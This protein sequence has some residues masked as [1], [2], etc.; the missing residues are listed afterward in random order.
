MKENSIG[1]ASGCL[2]EKLSFQPL[3]GYSPAN[4]R[5]SQF[6]QWEATIWDFPFPPFCLEQASQL[7]PFLY[8]TVFLS[9]ALWTCLWFHC[10]LHDPDYNFLLLPNKPIFAGKITFNFKINTCNRKCSI[11]SSISHGYWSVFSLFLS[12]FRSFIHLL[13]VIY[14]T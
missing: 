9:F 14:C 7:G 8:K 6:S 13:N 4:E 10:S 3:L 11:R 1:M 12:H 2:Q 5:Q